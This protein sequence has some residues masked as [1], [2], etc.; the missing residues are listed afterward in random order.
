MNIHF[1][2]KLHLAYA[3]HYKQLNFSGRYASKLP[4]FTLN[5]PCY[6]GNTQIISLITLNNQV[7]LKSPKYFF[8]ES[9]MLSEYTIGLQCSH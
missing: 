2:A 8:M 6:I 5:I 9:L 1:V 3:N 4:M 7:K